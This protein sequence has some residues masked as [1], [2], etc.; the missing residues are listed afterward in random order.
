MRFK[1]SINKKEA[2][3]TGLMCLF[4]LAA[5][6]QVSAYSVGKTSGMATLGVIPVL[7]GSLVML[8][9]VLC[10]FE[11]RLSPDDDDDHQPGLSK[12]RGC[13]GVSSGVFAFL[14]LGKYFG[15]VPA[16]FAFIFIMAL[17]DRRH[18]LSS[19]LFLSA[20][21]TLVAALALA[22]GPDLHIPLLN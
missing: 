3:A 20:S 5:V 6:L 16:I 15:L 18:T 10:L 4:G 17:G 1:V 7:L 12:W 2:L 11:S 21:V 22:W 8:F 19:A 14:I 9:G 13:C